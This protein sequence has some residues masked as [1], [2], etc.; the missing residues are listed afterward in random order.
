M[1][2][3]WTPL[4]NWLWYC[5]VASNRGF[6]AEVRSADRQLKDAVGK[7]DSS[8]LSSDSLRLLQAS[9]DRVLFL[10]L[11]LQFMEAVHGFGCTCAVLQT[12]AECHNMGASYMVLA[13]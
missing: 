5:C 9:A 10:F 6:I 2:P 13:L 12:L 4:L 1:F 11:T 7:N 3:C 8:L